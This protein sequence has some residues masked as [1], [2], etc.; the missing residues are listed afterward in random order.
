MALNPSEHQQNGTAGV[1]WVKYGNV[2]CMFL[3]LGMHIF[4]KT[5]HVKLIQL[6]DAMPVQDRLFTAVLPLGCGKASSRSVGK[7]SGV[8]HVLTG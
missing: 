3:P 5:S 1:E 2:C 7:G 6:L 4:C 8:N